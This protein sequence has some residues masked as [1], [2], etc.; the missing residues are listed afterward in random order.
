MFEVSGLSTINI[1][2]L[3]TFNVRFADTCLDINPYLLKLLLLLKNLFI[4]NHATIYLE[5]VEGTE[6]PP[7]ELTCQPSKP[8]YFVIWTKDPF[9][10][11][12][13]NNSVQFPDHTYS[14]RHNATSSSLV[15]RRITKPV[16]NLYKCMDEKKIPRRTVYFNSKFS[17]SDR[18]RNSNRII[19]E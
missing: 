1:R 3:S 8:G 19:I 9:T 15:I 18:S 17:V 7:V 12:A 16:S 5:I 10:I 2:Y 4:L 14:T 13:F 11:V 6:A